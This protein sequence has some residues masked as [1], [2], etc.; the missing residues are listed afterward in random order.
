MTDAGLAHLLRRILT[1]PTKATAEK[2]VDSAGADYVMLAKNVVARLTFKRS[3]SQNALAWKWATEISQ[4]SGDRTPQ[5]VHSY[6]KLHH[7][8]AIR[9]EDDDFRAVYDRVIRPLPY[10]DKL[11]LMGP[12]IDFPV[13]RDMKVGQMTRFMDAVRADWE[14]RGFALTQPEEFEDAA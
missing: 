9:K 1:A 4:Q 12:P 7:G 8:I 11:D 5:E 2:M 6:N 13:T 3:L 10:E 14:G